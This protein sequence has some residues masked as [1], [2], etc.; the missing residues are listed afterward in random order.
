[1]SLLSRL[2]E[3]LVLV[4]ASPAPAPPTP[5]P[6]SGNG[7]TGE[8]AG[9]PDGDGEGGAADHIGEFVGG[10]AAQLAAA[11]R[12]TPRGASSRRRTVG[13]AGGERTTGPQKGTTGKCHRPRMFCEETRAKTRLARC[14]LPHPHPHP[15]T[16][17]GPPRAS[18]ASHA[19]EAGAEAGSHFFG[20]RALLPPN[21]DRYSASAY[22]VGAP[23]CRVDLSSAR[24]RS[25]FLR[26][27]Y[28]SPQWS[29][30]CHPSAPLLVVCNGSAH[31]TLA[32]P[33]A[34]TGALRAALR[35]PLGARRWA[36]AT[37]AATAAILGPVA[38]VAIE[39][40]ASRRGI[41]AVWDGE[42]G[43]ESACRTPRSVWRRWVA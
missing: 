5:P 15:L 10:P 42:H 18:G 19:A 9:P 40:S 43:G 3:P 25:P 37:A 36:A 31:A 13:V 26:S 41:R 32:L 21:L 11:A 35:P 23:A 33:S 7:D 6:P 24:S 17:D 34:A 27:P 12:A 29:L 1:M 14:Y 38:P 20:V 8:R 30:A 39:G 2:G 22:K 16:P 4:R 28:H